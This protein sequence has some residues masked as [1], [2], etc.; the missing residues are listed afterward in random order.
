MGLKSVAS[1]HWER[2]RVAAGSP[3]AHNKLECVL[4]LQ[5][6]QLERLLGRAR[7]ETHVLRGAVQRLDGSVAALRGELASQSL[8]VARLLDVLR[9]AD[10]ERASLRR[11]SAAR[12][13]ERDIIATV[14]VLQRRAA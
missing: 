12:L 6:V 14:L 10:Q 3:L 1:E 9:Q 13:D 8:E 5:S 11:E 7:T 2:R 4:C